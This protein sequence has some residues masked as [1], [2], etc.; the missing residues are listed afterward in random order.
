MHKADVAKRSK[1]RL[2]HSVLILFGE[3][4]WGSRWIN[5][6]ESSNFCSVPPLESCLITADLLPR[7]G[8][9]KNH[10]YIKVDTL[11]IDTSHQIFDFVVV[12]NENNN[13]IICIFKG[14]VARNFG[15][16]VLF[17]NQ[18]YICRP[19]SHHSLNFSNFSFEFA[20]IFEFDSCSLGSDIP[21]KCF[22]RSFIPHG[23]WYRLIS[24]P[25]EIYW[26]GSDTPRL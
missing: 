17:M 2:C 7:V 8:Q 16:L 15:P 19:L 1:C 24:D 25:V 4:S 5:L 14:K 10:S 13:E 3:L 11:G 23:N 20:A 9:E 26:K 12:M 18:Y 21:H 22:Q 6:V